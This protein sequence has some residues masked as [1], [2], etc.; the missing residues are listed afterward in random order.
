MKKQGLITGNPSKIYKKIL[1]F[2]ASSVTILL[3]IALFQARAGGGKSLG[4]TLNES[5]TDDI[6]L[7]NSVAPFPSKWFS[8]KPEN[9]RAQR[10]MDK[11]LLSIL[12]WDDILLKEFKIVPGHNDMGYYGDDGNEENSVRPICYAVLVNAFLSKVQKYSGGTK[13]TEGRRIQMKDCAIKTLRYLTHSHVTGDGECTGGGKWGNHWQSS[14]WT[15]PA[16]MAGWILWEDLDQELKIRVARMLEYEANRFI[17]AEPKNQEFYDTGAEENA[18]NTHC[19]SLATN[20]MPYHPN[21]GKWDKAAK[22]FMYNSFSVAADL[23]DTTIEDDGQMVKQ[24]VTTINA[25]P[26]FTVENHGRLHIGYLKNTLCMQLENALNYE[27]M[28][29]QIPNAI[30]H[31]VPEVFENLKKSMMKDATVVLWGS[32]D[33]RIVHSQAIDIISY[34]AINLL[35]ADSA[36]AYLEDVAINYMHSLQQQNNGYFN[37]RRDLEW[38]GFAAT[39]IINAYLL[40]AILGAGS[41]PL[42]ETKYDN[43][44]NNVTYFPYGKTIIHR[45]ST[46]FASFSWNHYFLGLS[47]NKNGLWQNWPRESSYVGL[48]NGSEAN[49]KEVSI[50]SINPELKRDNFNITGKLR[51]NAKGLSLI[52]DVSFTSLKKDI[53]VYIERLTKISGAVTSRETGL[54]GHEFELLEPERILYTDGGTTVVSKTGDKSIKMVTNWLNIGGKIGYVVCRN[55]SENLMTYHSSIQKGFN[56]D[57]INLVGESSSEWASDWACV[58]TFLNQDQVNTAS[59]ADKVV[60][61]VVGNSATCK[62]GKEEVSVNFGE[63]GGIVNN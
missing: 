9:E 15:R 42:S 63:K 22:K 16:A 58:V 55:G 8:S 23:K 14:M 7:I 20:M 5:E 47:L 17:D 40:H 45:T 12:D 33:W 31:H 6:T 25:H 29:N 50:E 46:K 1:L 60:F 57:Y 10:L 34:A 4:I 32:N 41:T 35:N 61:K 54:V 62:I 51:R 37:L 2:L 27:L 21:R 49:E 48:I 52:Q 30:Y 28:G 56:C 11:Y 59:W 43:L 39:R 13:I 36:A 44:Y 24:W 18:W 19:T 26:D 53:T 3:F 38:S